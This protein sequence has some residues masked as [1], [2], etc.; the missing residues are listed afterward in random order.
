MRPHWHRSA[1]SLGAACALAI[2]HAWAQG[3]VPVI[4]EVPRP[5]AVSEE[6]RLTGTLTAERSARLSPRVDGLVARVRV[7]AGDAVKA[8]TPLIELDAAVARLAL[9]RAKANTAE[10]RARADEAQRLAVEAR[11]LVA[12]G[13]LPQTEVARRESEATLAA[14]AL[15]AA[16]AGEQ[17]QAELLRRHVVPASSRGV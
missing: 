3:A 5:A 6:L 2:T 8:G 17:E 15:V 1:A 10:T 14:A 7:D 13:H 11:R 4:V 16:G 9:A 12:E